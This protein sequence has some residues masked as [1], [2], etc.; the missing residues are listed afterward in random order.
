MKKFEGMHFY[1]NISNFDDVVE[2]EEQESGYVN[3]S[4]HALNTFF[5]TVEW[6]GKRKYGDD[7]VVEKV[8]GARL[9]MYIISDV[10]RSFMAVKNIAVF[11]YRL[12]R[13]LNEETS[14]YKKLK[15]FH[16]QIGADYGG[17]YDFVFKDGEY[18]EETTIGFAANYAA[19]LQILCKDDYFSVSSYVYDMVDE[20]DTDVFTR[21]ESSSIKKYEQKCY[22]TAKLGELCFEDDDC[23]EG[24]RY[25][26]DVVKKT[27]LADMNYEPARVLINPENLSMKNIKK[28]TGIPLFADIRDFTKQFNKDDINL[29]EMADKTQKILKT[30]YSVIKKNGVHI[31]FQGDR[32]EALFHNYSDR[33]CAVDAV[34]A[35]MRIIDSV[36][37][38]KVNVG[39]GE[40]LG[41]VF[42][43]RIGARG[44]KDNILIGRTV[45]ESDRFEDDYAE[46]NQLVISEQI[47]LQLKEEKPILAE[48]FTKAQ[49]YYVTQVGYKKFCE[50]VEDENHIINNKEQNY[51]RAWCNSDKHRKGQSLL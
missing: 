21:V 42:V 50:A 46:A 15:D 51:N 7:F 26:D 34:I 27:N 8:T 41:T 33:N 38:Y 3:H 9:H 44:N 39:V 29:K 10:Y 12:A 23:E 49:G 25:A 28:V 30:M 16:I 19:K 20:K 32:E 11:A 36:K 2:K 14:K 24:L 43:S 40:S 37:Q 6:F 13:Y 48:Q 22:Y 31:Q 5:S 45:T 1:I 47:Y 18:E 4:I 17:F 35:A